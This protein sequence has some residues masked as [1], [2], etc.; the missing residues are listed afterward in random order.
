M[1]TGM[2]TLDDARL[3]AFD[4]GKTSVTADELRRQCKKFDEILGHGQV[5]IRH[6]SWEFDPATL[7]I[8]HTHSGY[9]IDLEQATDAPSLLDQILQIGLKCNGDY[10]IDEA[11]VLLNAVAMLRGVGSLQGAL[12]PCER[13]ARRRIRWGKPTIPPEDDG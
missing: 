13:A 3:M 2:V 4:N 6:R 8:R 1:T 11:I 12:C 5:P 7:V 9:E 10:R